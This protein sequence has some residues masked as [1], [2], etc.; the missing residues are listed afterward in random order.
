MS[1]SMIYERFKFML[2]PSS[3]QPKPC[4]FPFFPI[5]TLSCAIENGT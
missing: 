1:M 5:L 2:P 4:T 3:P